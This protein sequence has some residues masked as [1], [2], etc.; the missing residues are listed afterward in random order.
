MCNSY[1]LLFPIESLPDYMLKIFSGHKFTAGVKAMRKLLS[2]AREVA[3]TDIL[4]REYVKSGG[5]ER[6]ISDFYSVKPKNVRAADDQK[7]VRVQKNQTSGKH[8]RKMYTPF[9]PTFI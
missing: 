4:R 1:R 2:G 9:N 8:V 6:A 7:I 5:A 3:P